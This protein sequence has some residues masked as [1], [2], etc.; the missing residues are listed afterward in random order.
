MVVDRIVQKLEEHN[1]ADASSLEDAERI[2]LDAMR[3]VLEEDTSTD[4]NANDEPRIPGPTFLASTLTRSR[5]LEV[6]KIHSSS[7]V[8]EE[9]SRKSVDVEQNDK[10]R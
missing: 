3:N 10:D 4:S 6:R 1:C 2:V 7:R 8:D 5:G 9:H